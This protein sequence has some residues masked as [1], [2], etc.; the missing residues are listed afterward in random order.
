MHFLSVLG[1]GGDVP[2]L[3]KALRA[4]RVA[5][6]TGEAAGWPGVW[7]MCLGESGGI[8]GAGGYC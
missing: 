7:A 3:T 4:G 2:F 5:V 8:G 1:G 6:Q